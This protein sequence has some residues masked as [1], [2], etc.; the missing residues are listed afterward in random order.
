MTAI[1]NLLGA[2]PLIV[3]RITETMMSGEDAVLRQVLTRPDL[4]AITES[5]QNAP[6]VSVVF[7]GFVVQGGAPAEL[8]HAAQLAQ[9]WLTVITVK[10]IADSKGAAARN[11]DAGPILRRLWNALHG[12]TLGPGFTPLIP[13]SPPRAYYSAGFAYFPLAWSTSMT[14][15]RSI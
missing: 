10:N 2:E 7:D 14:M 13:V 15:C 5:M 6:A 4:A 12:H 1:D 8:E 11:Q 9:R 3:A